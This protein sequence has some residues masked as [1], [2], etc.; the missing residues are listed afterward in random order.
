MNLACIYFYV[1]PCRTI[2]MD[3]SKS[4]D[5]DQP[6]SN[7][8]RTRARTWTSMRMTNALQPSSCMARFGPALH[9]FRFTTF[10]WM[11]TDMQCPTGTFV[12]LAPARGLPARLRPIRPVLF[13]TYSFK[14]ESVLQV[15]RHHQIHSRNHG[16][17]YNT[18]TLSTT[19]ER[20]LVL[21]RKPV[22]RILQATG[23]LPTHT[24]RTN[25]VIIQ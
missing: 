21:N 15:H 12:S 3:A 24:S 25:H 1:C 23:H 13:P 22:P 10:L 8:S 14:L 17:M 20:T 2:V 6:C 19:F 7:S 11:R 4:Y 16:S 9:V 18:R 5:R